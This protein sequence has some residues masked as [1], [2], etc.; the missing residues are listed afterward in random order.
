[1]ALVENYCVD[2]FEAR[3]YAREPNGP[4]A[5]HP[6]HE[7]PEA[8][9][10]YEARS[11]ADVIPQAYIDRD[12]AS[13]ACENSSK[14]LCTVSEWYRACRGA[15]LSPYSYGK[16]FVKGR[17]NTSKPHLLSLLFGTNPRAWKYDEHFN[18]PGL[19]Q[20]EGFLARTGQYE[21]CV[22]D[23]GVHDMVGNLHE[24]VS[25]S[26]DR[27]LALK[28][29]LL[30]G[31]QRALRRTHGHGIFMG[32]FFSTTAEHGR[33]CAFVTIGHSPRYHD[34]STGFRCCRDA[35]ELARE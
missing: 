35:E 12:E 33:G 30:P 24:W 2:R 6:A 10:R 22:S 20:L 15:S 18:N 14:R 3:L 27:S 1:M 31:I 23:E 19:N 7:R 32:G 4:L 28:L 9:V 26:V 13:M 29:P 5:P 17:C 25:D 11:E 8:G 16:R 21:Q 34:Y